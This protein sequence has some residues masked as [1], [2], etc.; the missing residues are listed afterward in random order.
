MQLMDLLSQL[1]LNLLRALDALLAERNVT[2]AAKRLG[3]SQ[4]ATSHALQRLR[5]TLDDPILVRDGRRMVP[6]PRAEALAPALSATLDDLRR[7]LERG[8]RF[9]P[10]TATARFSLACP[11]GLGPLI[12]RILAALSDAPGVSLEVRSSAG[13][14]A[15]LSAD[16]V[17]EAMPSEAPGLVARGLGVVRQQVALRRG[18]PLLDG[19]WTLERYVAWPHVLVHDGRGGRSIVEQALEA[20]GV[21]RRVGLEV[22]GWLLAAHVVAETDLLFTSAGALLAPLCAPLGLRLLEPPLPVP[23]VPVAALWPERLKADPGHRWFRERV[24]EVATEVLR[25]PEGK[26]RV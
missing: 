18:H 14:I 7:L 11:N 10:A 26:R 21:R 15:D 12:P 9:D 1:D 5:D 25:A 6:T 17:L 20:A 4:S 16:V 19:P 3:L 22:N 13:D 24:I 23:E 8:T 2:R